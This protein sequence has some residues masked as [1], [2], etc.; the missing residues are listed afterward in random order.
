MEK[1]G[2]I[3]IVKEDGEIEYNTDEESTILMGEEKISGHVNRADEKSLAKIN[4][5]I[6]VYGLLH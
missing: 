2:R 3:K 5:N 6:K 1:P 4:L